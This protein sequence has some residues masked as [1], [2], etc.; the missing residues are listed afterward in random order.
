MNILLNSFFC[1]LHVQFD[2]III[3][4]VFIYKIAPQLSDCTFSIT[5]KTA[6][7]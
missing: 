7:S 4:N 5:F 1:I 2:R 3:A 6:H